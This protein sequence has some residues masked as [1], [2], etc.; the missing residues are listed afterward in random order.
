MPAFFDHQ[1]VATD[2]D[3]SGP[4]DPLEAP[5]KRQLDVELRQ[6]R[7]GDGWKP[8]IAAARRDRAFRDDPTEGV[9]RIEV[10]D[11]AAELALS[12]N[13][14]ERAAA[15]IEHGRMSRDRRTGGTGDVALDRAARE[16]Q[17]QPPVSVVGHRLRILGVIQ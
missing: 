5:E 6:L 4:A 3:L 15:P 8:R 7:G 13:R 16:L 10:P 17:E 2:F 1:A 11:A 14:H 9:V 12:V